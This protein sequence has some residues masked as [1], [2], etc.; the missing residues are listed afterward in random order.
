[1]NEK[2]PENNKN[3]K[4]RAAIERLKK[5]AANLIEKIKQQEIENNT[6]ETADGLPPLERI[7]YFKYHS[8]ASLSKIRSIPY[9]EWMGETINDEIVVVNYRN[10]SVIVGAGFNE[11][12]ARQN[13]ELVCETRNQTGALVHNNTITINDINEMMK[14][15]W[16]IPAD[17]IEE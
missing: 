5:K 6:L 15:E 17:Y 1:M 16:K 10:G 4:N 3:A 9:K 14:L 11:I 8:F 12:K 7:N 2:T 13:M